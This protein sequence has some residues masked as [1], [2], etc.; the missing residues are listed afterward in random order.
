MLGFHL[1]DYRFSFLELAG[2][3]RARFH[4]IQHSSLGAVFA[5][6]GSCTVVN[7]LRTHLPPWAP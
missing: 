1:W 7:R 6:P 3:P 4:T 5:A 2:P